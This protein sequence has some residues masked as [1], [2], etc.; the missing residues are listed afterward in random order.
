MSFQQRRHDV[1]LTDLGAVSP[2]AACAHSDSSLSRS[3]CPFSAAPT[4]GEQGDRRNTRTLSDYK[5][6]II[7]S[8]IYTVMGYRSYIYRVRY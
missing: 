4:R 8:Y 1:D 6:G 2:D 3:A 7:Y 5:I